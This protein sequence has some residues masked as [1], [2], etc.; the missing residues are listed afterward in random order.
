LAREKEPEPMK[1][2][3][4]NGGAPVRSSA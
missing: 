1:E 4:I 3:A 2:L